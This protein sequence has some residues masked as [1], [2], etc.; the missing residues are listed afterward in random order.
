MGSKARWLVGLL[1]L[2]FLGLLFW[3]AWSRDPDFWRSTPGLH[4]LAQEAA[5]RG[6][7]A[8][9]L[10]LAR[11]VRSRE[12]RNSYYAVFL[13]QMYLQSGQPRGALEIG[14]QVAAEHPGTQVAKLQAQAL[15]QLGERQAALEV[16]AA[17][18]Q[19]QPEDR[20]ILETAA[21]LAAD[22]P[23]T[24][25][26]AVTY[27]ER[28]YRLSGDPLAR[29]H[30]VDLLASLNR[31]QEA[32][33]IQEEEVAQFPENRE[34]LHQLALLYYWQRDYQASTRIYQRLLEKAAG[35]AGLRLEA[36]KS[37]EAAQDLDQALT[38]YLWLYG[39]HGA[40]QE[41]ALALA[42]LWD[43]KGNH[44]EAA[45]I[46]A[47]LMADQPSLELR[48]WYALELLLVGDFAKALKTYQAAW[49]AG[50]S[51]QESPGTG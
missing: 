45:G 28:L 7:R 50:D 1:P 44:V 37:A 29:R 23:E 43:R 21:A 22:R 39:H 12:P 38:Q 30:L 42:R 20:E 24:H 14:R 31:F 35:D 6:D 17:H 2:C 41:Y 33:P 3:A 15:E 11:K 10:D 51:N 8:R 49:E 13:G 9:A 26:L 18:L 48:R 16:L 40:K 36:A 46:L 32:I 5:A 25:P 47:P 4:H 27:Y 34:S 19:R